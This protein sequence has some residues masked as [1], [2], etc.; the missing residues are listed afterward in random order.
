MSR[1]AFD[2]SVLQNETITLKTKKPLKAL[3]Q[4]I[5][6]PA[7]R[8]LLGS[9]LHMTGTLLVAT[10]A[11]SL[12]K[13]T[14]GDFTDL[15]PILMYALMC[16]IGYI[17]FYASVVADLGF[18]DLAAKV[19]K[20]IWKKVM[21]L[22]LSFFNR[23]NS[24]KVLSRITSDPEYAYLPLKLLQLSFTLLILLLVVLT[25]DAAIREAALILV[26]GFILT[27]VIMFYAARFSERGA[28]YVAGKLAS[29]TSYLAE[30]FGHI[31]FIKAM[32]SEEA[33]NA[34]S[35]RL[36]EER[37]EADK[38]NAFAQTA[39]A[40]GQSFIAL[41]L[42]TAAFF[43][44][45]FLIKAGKVTTTTMIVAFYAYGGNMVTVFQFFTQIPSIFAA[46][47]GGTKKLV[48]ILEEDEEALD[49]GSAEV[50]AAGDLCLENL[51]FGYGDTD[52]LK[53][54]SAVI[55]RGKITAI[56]GLNGSGKT[57][58][59]RILQRLYPDH[60]GGLFLC[61]DSGEKTDADRISLRSWRSRFGLVS[62]NAVLFEGTIRENICYGVKEPQEDQLQNVIR[63]ACLED[64]VK[65]HEGGLNFNVGVNGE[66]LSGGERQRVAI[67]RAMM[68][69]PDY[70]I[71]D[72]STANLDPVTEEK[73]RE[74]VAKITQGRT[75]IVVAH[76]FNAVKN[77]DRVLVMNRGVLEDQ[78]TIE[79]LQA[80][81]AFF[82]A[83]SAKY[84]G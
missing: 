43:A 13:I 81:N 41:M 46:T 37:Y 30:R 79:E 72:E 2:K 80:R 61:A 59:T 4:G 48:Q 16:T 34:A 82:Q 40:F 71:L 9:L 15:S 51:S 55:P 57:T 53:D 21:N 20:K 5:K 10:Q 26:L 47:R 49:T 6:L 50:P 66:K 19:R 78:G 52:V 7:F 3:F 76:S 60:R 83:F 33:E 70:L 74:S 38:Y 77:A 1:K 36:I 56:V 11:D 14:V 54:V 29:F 35:F 63:L 45:I 58:V 31:R 65:N 67:A 17:F 62:Q 18:V 84:Q 73:I 69:N 12:A 8:T 64:V 25:G 42:F 23:E 27:M 39:V 22:P 68:T 32:N 44:G 24:N 75:T 28:T